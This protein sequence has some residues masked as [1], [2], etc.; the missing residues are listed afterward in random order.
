M[1]LTSVSSQRFGKSNLICVGDVKQS[2]Y[3]FRM[4]RPELFIQKYEKYSDQDDSLE[5]R[6]NLDFNFRSRKQIINAVNTVF[7]ATM[8][9]TLGG[10]EYDADNRLYFGADYSEIPEKQNNEMEILVVEDTENNGKE[11]EAVAIAQ[12]IKSIIDSGFLVKDKSTGEMRTAKYSDI[13][14][15]LRGVKGWSDVFEEVFIQKE[16]QVTVK[17]AKDTLMQWK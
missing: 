15:L 6:I 12:K 17:Q 1:I 7:E 2:I 13:V 16:S 10:I 4:A 8:K 11:L 5:Q 3:K 14:I 9:K